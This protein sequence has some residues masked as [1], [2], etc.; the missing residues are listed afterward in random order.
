V[1]KIIIGLYYALL[2]CFA[3]PAGSILGIPIKLLITVAAFGLFIVWII[4]EKK[5]ITFDI[6]LAGFVGIFI[7]ISL[8]SML[9]V[10]NGYTSSM[11][12]CLKSF[13][14]LLSVVIISYVFIKNRIVEVTRAYK[15]LYLAAVL[16]VVFKYVSEILMIINLVDWLSF[17]SF[18]TNVLDASL[19]TMQ[20]NIGNII[21]YRIMAP[22]D[23]LPLV[24]L[25]FYLLFEKKS[26]IYK[27]VAM[28]II[29][30]YTFIVYSRVIIIQYLV[31]ILMYLFK[32]LVQYLRFT[33][34][35]RT[36]FML[37]LKFV[38]VGVLG[39][40][41]TIYSEKIEVIIQESI[42]L[43]EDRF[44]GSS[45]VYSDSFR[46]EQKEY[47]E[48]GIEKSPLLG[49]GLGSY[50]KDY[51][52]S[53]AAPY[54]YEAEY[55]SFI[56]QFGYIG[57]ILIIGSIISLFI[58]ICLENVKTFWIFV[59]A[60]MNLAIWAIKPLFNPQ[61]LSSNSGM[62]IVAILIATK[63]YLN[64]NSYECIVQEEI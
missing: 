34:K 59:I 51:V 20:M 48:V 39:M 25:G 35:R 33:S 16:C 3:L 40:T 30:G 15:I 63:Y 17:R 12:A 5:E 53:T 28:I 27:F 56:Y 64:V 52:R 36:I 54:S 42:D 44:F 2:L 46:D 60:F 19:T 58:K 41:V 55:L 47:L 14:S 32:E 29:G 24:L 13:I 18:F 23:S 7:P 38:F 22:N 43:I 61:F 49:H 26:I 9:S 31:I 45:A 8:W 62:I 6:S 1:K 50:V 21:I 57:F 10:A 11:I 4:I 37:C